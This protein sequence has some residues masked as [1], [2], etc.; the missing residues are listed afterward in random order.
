MSAQAGHSSEMTNTIKSSGFSH[1]AFA[2]ATETTRS[3]LL[4][5]RPTLMADLCEAKLV[6]FTSI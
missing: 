6:L 2:A 5:Q 4:W 3:L 1:V